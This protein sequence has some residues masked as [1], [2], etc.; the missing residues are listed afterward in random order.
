ME[1]FGNMG[2]LEIYGKSWDLENRA[3]S[4]SD[5]EATIRNL[6]HEIKSL[7]SEKDSDR[8]TIYQLNQTISQQSKTIREQNLKIIKLLEENKIELNKDKYTFEQFFNIKCSVRSAYNVLERFMQ[9]TPTWDNLTTQ[10]LEQ[11][12]VWICSN[13]DL[14]ESTAITYLTYIKNVIKLGYLNSSDT[15]LAIKTSKAPKEQRIWLRPSQIRL[16]MGY[17]TDDLTE[18]YVRD[19][20]TV[21]TLTGCRIID[22]PLLTADNIDGCTLRYIPIKTNKKECFVPLTKKAKNKLLEIFSKGGMPTQKVNYKILKK[23]C[24]GVGLTH[25]MSV[26]TPKHPRSVRICDEITFHTAR[27]SFATINYRYSN[28]TERQLA[29]AIGHTNFSQTAESYIIDKT[30]VSV[31]EMRQ[32]RDDLFSE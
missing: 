29:D 25:K 28:M 5:N 16:I 32:N 26:G 20:F 19:M 3:I 13:S 31:E 1:G 17:K 21:C 15:S 10:K 18:I 12:N 11:F 4:N 27:R 22:A 6:R 9:T 14:K 8:S 7:R 2:D 23:I 30:P 24:E